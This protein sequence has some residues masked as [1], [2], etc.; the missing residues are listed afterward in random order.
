MPSS[1]RSNPE[2]TA[3]ARAER[4]RLAAMRTIEDPAALAKAVRAV[5]AALQ[6]NR[7]T[8]AELTDTAA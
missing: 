1:D 5:R 6:H 4:Q 7:L 8:V 3:A 2:R